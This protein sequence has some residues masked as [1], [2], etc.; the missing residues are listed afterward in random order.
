MS[1]ED[2]PPPYQPY[3]SPG[4][5]YGYGYGHGYGQPGFGHQPPQQSGLAIA[6]LVTGILGT[7]LGL[8]GFFGF[9]GVVGIIGLGGIICGALAKKEIR[10]SGGAKTGDGMALA[11]IIT[12]SI[13]VAIALA[14]VALFVVVVGA[15]SL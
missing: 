6:S 10:R 5:G 1:H 15:Y 14:N 8:C 13:G 9:F 11:G 7:V 12:G 2:P 4:H 3:A